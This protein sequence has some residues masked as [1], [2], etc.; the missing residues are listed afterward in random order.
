MHVLSAIRAVFDLVMN[1]QSATLYMLPVSCSCHVRDFCASRGS[2][3]RRG[4]LHALWF[5][6]IS[7][8]IFHIHGVPHDRELFCT[9]AHI[10][11]SHGSCSSACAGRRCCGAWPWKEAGGWAQLVVVE[12]DGTMGW[13]PASATLVPEGVGR[14][15]MALTPVEPWRVHL[16]TA[17]W[18]LQVFWVALSLQWTL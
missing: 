11:N 15:G 10:H 2:W 17:C 14:D 13:E 18:Y 4:E 6:I 16:D 1:V 5:K 12:G 8:G 3:S 7:S 9:S